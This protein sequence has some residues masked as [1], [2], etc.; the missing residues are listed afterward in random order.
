MHVELITYPIHMQMSS[1]FIVLHMQNIADSTDIKFKHFSS[2]SNKIWCDTE[3]ATFSLN[4]ARRIW[5]LLPICS[6]ADKIMEFN[7]YYGMCIVEE[8]I[9]DI[10]SMFYTD[11]ARLYVLLNDSPRLGK[12]DTYVSLS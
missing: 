7:N 8:K 9:E 3:V 11:D 12:Q 10:V 5:S 6:D 4:K 1:K 2:K